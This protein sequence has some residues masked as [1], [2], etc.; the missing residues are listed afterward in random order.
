VFF[1]QRTP[2]SK[3]AAV[4]DC[5]RWSFQRNI[6]WFRRQFAQHASLPFASVLPAR[7]VIACIE[8][9]GLRFY[10][11]LFN[12]VTVLWLFL[13]QVVHAN[14]TLAA[15]VEG[16]LAWR[17]AQG[18]P[19]CSVD[20]GGYAKARRRLPEALLAMLTKHTGR[21]AERAAAGPWRWL[22]RVVK[23]FDGSTVS[24]PDTPENQAA[25]PQSRTQTPG[26]GF[27]LARIGVLFSLSVG[28]VLELGIRRWAGK[29]QSELAMLRDM[30][31]TLEAGDVLLADRYL[32]SYTE[33]ALLQQRG[34]DFVGRMHA[35]RKVDFRRGRRLGVDDHVVEW[36]RP[37][38]PEWMSPKQYATIPLRLSIRE[39]RY[40]VVRPGYRTRT[41]VVATTLLDAA[42]Y[43]PE[44]MAELYR[45][46]WDAEINL[47]SLKTIMNMDV[48]RCQTPDMV[49]KEI[50]AHLLAYNL[51]RTVIAQAAARHG[52]HPRQISFT[53]AMRTL[54]AFRPTLAHATSEQLPDLYQ[55]LLQVIASHEIA[56]R[57]DRLEPRK[58]K[59]RPKPYPLMTKPRPQARKQ[60]GKTR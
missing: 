16:F 25:F 8:S 43:S 7:V 40:R 37:A 54:E 10:N 21:E 51:I 1:N 60:E 6:N 36:V 50:W 41:I 53:R 27:P 34:V 29:L 47:R 4:S 22:G 17:L 38:R 9:L 5:S 18:M 44:E 42:V 35:H 15:T 13:S 48:L 32:C 19:P 33:I 20:T 28:T 57:P 30:M 46:R 55:H 26:V 12:P 3:E 14:P 58:R 49:R 52:K 23:M 31:A 56:N 11:S 45:L 24:M 2:G 39:F 59:R